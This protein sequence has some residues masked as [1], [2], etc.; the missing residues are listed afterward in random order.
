[1]ILITSITFI[2]LLL[3]SLGLSYLLISNYKAYL[4]DNAKTRLDIL[5]F[6][7]APALIFDDQDAV[8]QLLLSFETSKDVEL[9]L[10]LKSN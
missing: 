4:H 10:V 6:N 1:M 5:A 7:M 9:A 8:E 3:A 2:S